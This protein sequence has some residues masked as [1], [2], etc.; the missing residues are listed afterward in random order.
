M[1]R[2]R[3]VLKLSGTFSLILVLGLSFLI[4][5]E[6]RAQYSF[7]YTAPTTQKAG[8]LGDTTMFQSTLTNTGDSADFDV[9]MVEKPPTPVA[10]W[11]RF[12]SGGICWDSSYN[13]APIPVSLASGDSGDILLEIMPRTSGIANVTMRITSR[14]NPSLSDSITFTL[15]LRGDANSDGKISVSDVVYM[16][17]YLFKGGPP[18]VPLE[19]ADINCDRK[20]DVSDVVYLINYL[21]KGGPPPCS[22]STLPLSSMN[23][24]CYSF[25]NSRYIK[26]AAGVF[27]T[28]SEGL[29]IYGTEYRSTSTIHPVPLSQY[30]IANKTL[31]FKWKANGGGGFMGVFPNIF[32]DSVSWI[33]PYYPTNLTTHHS[34]LDSY[35]ITE[36]MWYY[37]RIIVGST[38]Y[39]ATTATGNYD[40]AG[41]TVV[42]TKTAALDHDYKYLCFGPTD[43]YAGTAAYVILGEV[44]IE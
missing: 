27:E 13:Y 2:S 7:T 24:A 29:K 17:N 31:Y 3:K 12:C 39:T 44:R 34:Y 35:V 1:N 4:A 40:N 10:W 28:V 21:F 33:S 9:D 36:D 42:Q 18:P 25:T 19:S 23:W 15:N 20:L 37:T 32:T 22:Y 26:P 16:I 8:N 11:M 41:G 6:I 43:C 5:S 14:A 30:P 38:T